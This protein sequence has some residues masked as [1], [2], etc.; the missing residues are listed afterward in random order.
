MTH[1]GEPTD[2]AWAAV[3]EVTD[4]ELPFLSVV[5]LGIVRALVID[6]GGAAHVT[7]TQTYSGCPAAEVIHRDVAS[8]LERAGFGPVTVTETLSPPWT[9]DWITEKGHAALLA[10]GIAPPT[11]HDSR[12]RF[13]TPVVPCPRCGTTDTRQVSAFGSTACKALH[14][15]EAC[16][17]PFEAFKCL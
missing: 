17:E 5:D 11:P 14:T 13:S 8:R 1:S 16:M 6:D 7:I 12:A 3:A 15:C 4:P 2:A 9:T 10:H